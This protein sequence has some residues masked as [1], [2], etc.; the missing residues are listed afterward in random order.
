MSKPYPKELKNYFKELSKILEGTVEEIASV[1][2][3]HLLLSPSK[4]KS[5]KT[6]KQKHVKK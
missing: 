2:I 5:K 4:A 6:K 1:S 3:K